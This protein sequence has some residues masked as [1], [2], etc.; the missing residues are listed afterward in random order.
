M[1]YHFAPGDHDQF[2]CKHILN[3]VE[4]VGAIEHTDHEDG[5]VDVGFPEA[6]DE[7]YVAARLLTYVRA[8]Y[9]PPA[10]IVLTRDE[11]QKL[12]TLAAAKEV[13]AEPV[14]S[15]VKA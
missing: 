13:S 3:G 11:V 12:K 4:V 15:G 6:V 1:I 10:P 5:S 14:Q 7:A 2:T 8:D 9:E